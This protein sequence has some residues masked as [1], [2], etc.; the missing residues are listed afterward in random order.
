MPKK[1]FKK[2]YI[3]KNAVA[4]AKEVGLEKMS[5]RKLAKKMNCSVTPI[6]DTYESKEDLI[7][8]V[9]RQVIEENNSSSNYFIRNKEILLYGIK[10]PQLY[11]DIR[12]QSAKSQQTMHYYQ[13]VIALMRK[14][15]RLREFNDNE[16]ESLNFDILIYM[17]GLVERSIVETGDFENAEKTF[18]TFLDQVTELFILGYSTAKTK[19][20]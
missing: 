16:L 1:V 15:E 14:E 12:R 10:Y 7:E 17:N 9:Y 11:R 3:L 2:Q 19:D 6:Y 4:L 13:E 5:M 18:S 8:A 20:F